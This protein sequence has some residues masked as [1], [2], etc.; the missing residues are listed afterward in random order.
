MPKNEQRP[1]LNSILGKL[2]RKD[3][4]IGYLRTIKQL[5]GF[6]IQNLNPKND[7]QEHITNITLLLGWCEEKIRQREAKLVKKASH[8]YKLYLDNL[9]K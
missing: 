1:N 8:E 4:D 6:Y 3:E 2:K 7:N 9:E 5:A